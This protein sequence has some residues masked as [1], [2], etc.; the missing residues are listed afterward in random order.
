METD[1]KVLNTDVS[2]LNFMYKKI[3]IPK[4][5]MAYWMQVP[6]FV[7]AMNDLVDRRED[8]SDKAVYDVMLPIY[9]DVLRFKGTDAGKA[10]NYAQLRRG[11]KRLEEALASQ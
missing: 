3:S 6:E 1:G 2:R 7:S 5:A 11:V 8:I 4:M 9:E 10:F